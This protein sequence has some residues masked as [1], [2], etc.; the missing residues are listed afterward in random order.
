MGLGTPDFWKCELCGAIGQ[1]DLDFEAKAIL[2]SRWGKAMARK[3]V[4]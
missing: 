3:P 2:T 1:V 4:E